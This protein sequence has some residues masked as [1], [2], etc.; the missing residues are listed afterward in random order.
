MNGRGVQGQWAAPLEDLPAYFQRNNHHN[1][2]ERQPIDAVLQLYGYMTFNDN[3]YGILNNMQYAWFF[4][5][6]KT[7]ERK[8]RTLQYYRPIDI[9]VDSIH[10]PSILEAYVGTMHM[11]ARRNCI[12]LVSHFRIQYRITP[13]ETETPP[14]YRHSLI[15]RLPWLDH[16]QSCHSI[17][18]FAVSTAVLCAI[19]PDEVT[20]SAVMM[21]LNLQGIVI[22]RVHGYYNVSGL[23]KLLALEVIGT[24]IPEEMGMQMK[25]ALN[26]IH[27]AGYD[28]AR[29]NFCKRGKRIFLADLETLAVGLAAVD[30]L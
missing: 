28:I 20:F 15:T 8:G 30:A 17:L 2:L 6:V 25:S 4:Q 23:L 16:I 27:S 7:A 3:K 29:R 22:P 11:I 18:G 1:V 21:P 19:L 10:T 14:S 13:S 12:H 5:P 24:A 26:R 9:D